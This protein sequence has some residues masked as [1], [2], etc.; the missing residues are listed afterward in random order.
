MRKDLELFIK[1]AHKILQAEEE[2][3]VVTPIHPKKMHERF[4]LALSDEP[5]DEEK[6]VESLEDIILHTPRAASNQFFNQLTGGR[7]SKATLGELLAVMLNVTMSTYKVAGPQVGVEQVVIRE[8][9]NIIGYNKD[10]SG[11]MAPGGSMTI[12]MSML[13]A[14]D[15]FNKDLRNKG[16]KENMTLYTSVESH[17]S[18]PKNASFIG[19][20]RDNV[21]YIKTNDQGQ[22]LASDLETQI[23]KDIEAGN[24]PFYVNATI[25]TTVLSVIDPVNEIADVCEKYNVWLHADGAYLGSII[26]S[27]KYSKLAKGLNRTHSFSINPHKMLNTPISTSIIVTNH[28]EC[29]ANTFSNEAEY[30][31]QT[32]SDEHNLG[33]ISMQCGRRNDALKFWC[34]WKSVGTKGLEEIVDHEFYLADV[35]REYVENN[36]NYTL[37]SFENSIAVCFNYKNIPA[38]ELCTQL[39]REGEL[40]VGYGKFKEDEFIRFI[41]VNGGNK[42]E[43]ILNFFKKLEAFADKNF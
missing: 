28:N 7:N 27:D 1:I 42:K 32:S 39:Y 40:M 19:V 37:Y 11:T 21:R 30:L 20:G 8:I 15:Y 10:S 3:P 34:L 38:T 26:F 16:V 23:K 9:C 5:M 2:V 14:R 12:L 4:D 24:Q 6:F 33:K 13:M 41:T 18:V 31:Y 35:A 36:P 17:Y 43:D 29:L 25:G 22:M